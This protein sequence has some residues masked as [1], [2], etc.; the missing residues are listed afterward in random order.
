MSTVSVDYNVIDTINITNIHK[1]L[2]KKHDK[3]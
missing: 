3:K 2:M 1:Y